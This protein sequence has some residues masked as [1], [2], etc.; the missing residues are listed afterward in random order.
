MREPNSQL[1]VSK[2]SPLTG[3]GASLTEAT[4]SSAAQDRIADLVVAAEDIPTIASQAHLELANRTLSAIARYV[5]DVEAEHKASKAPFL[6]AGRAIDAAKNKALE[7]VL[8]IQERLKKAAREWL[9]AEN[10]RIRREEL[11]R[12]AEVARLQREAAEAKAAAK[13]AANDAAA[14]ETA[15]IL[16]EKKLA[17]EKAAADA[18][19]KADEEAARKQAEEIARKEAWDNSAEGKAE[20]TRLRQEAEAKRVADEAAAAA[21]QKRIADEQARLA[22]ERATS[23]ASEKARKQ[24]AELASAVHQTAIE[25]VTAQEPEKVPT[26]WSF[27][28]LG[29]TEPDRKYQMILL[30][31]AY[32]DLFEIQPKTREF[33]A[34]AKQVKAGEHKYEGVQFFEEAVVR[35]QK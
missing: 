3:G 1:I 10:Q 4:L 12:Q 13:K 14:A 26:R 16:Q 20:A 30:A 21:E 32:P 29:M 24:E 31:A 34:L 9:D 2:W 35:T 18:K 22:Q 6:S 11:R 33:M 19:K 23:E 25:T 28:F 8:P 5:D 17:D 15:R 27:R 7:L